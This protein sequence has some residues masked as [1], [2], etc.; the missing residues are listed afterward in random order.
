MRSVA[1]KIKNRSMT[2]TSVIFSAKFNP[3]GPN[4]SE[5]INKHRHLLETDNTLKQLFPK[6]SVIVANKRGQ[7]LQELLT[8]ADPYNIKSDS[9]NLNDHVCLFHFRY[10]HVITSRK[11]RLNK[12]G[13]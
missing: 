2:T 12:C 1:R 10:T 13:D 3:R 9:L 4:G 8:R 6:N 5:I 11:F 7:N